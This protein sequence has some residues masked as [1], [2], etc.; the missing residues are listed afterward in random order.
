MTVHTDSRHISL[1]QS[2]SWSH[3]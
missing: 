3:A 1:E 2:T